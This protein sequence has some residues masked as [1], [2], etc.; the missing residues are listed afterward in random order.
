M[1]EAFPHGVMRCWSGE[2]LLQQCCDGLGVFSGLEKAEGFEGVL[3][4]FAGRFQRPCE[5]VQMRAAAGNP[6]ECQWFEEILAAEGCEAAA[7][8][9]GVRKLVKLA[10]FPER[11]PYDDGPGGDSFCL[12]RARD[13]REFR[14]AQE[15]LPRF[16]RGACAGGR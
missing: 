8:E 9:N 6:A 10:E 5:V 12:L 16:G 14:A 3:F 15:R 1:L 11:V 7:D 13:G 4:G 2:L